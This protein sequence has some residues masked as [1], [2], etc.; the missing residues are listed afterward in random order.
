MQ[1]II[2]GNRFSDPKKYSWAVDKVAGANANHWSAQEISM[3]KDISQWKLG[4]IS[5]DEQLLV[6][7]NLG[8]FSTADSLAANNIILGLLRHIRA[9][10]VRNFLHRQAYDEG[11]HSEAYLYIVQSLG[12]DEAEIFNAYQEIPSIRD[13]DQFLIPFI[14]VL[15]DPE[16]E[17]G[18]FENDQALLKSVFV[19]SCLMEGLFFYTGFVQ[20]LALGRQNKLMGASQEYQLILKDESL[21][22]NFGI[23]LFN[24][25]KLECPE[26]WTMELKAE[27][28]ELM[29]QAV[30]LEY[31]Y[32]EDTMPRGVLGLNKE[33]F[34]SYLQFIANRR[35]IQC[36]M[37]SIYAGATN[38][39]P[40]LATMID[41]PREASFFEVNVT[42]YQQGSSL[43][44]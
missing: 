13:K 4:Q 14:N 2:H 7:R 42:T 32:A 1:S 20:I 27:L 9:E 6:K 39:F 5:P 15:A 43:E 24:T 41:Q 35:M 11:V 18:T 31:K 17:T 34:H 23:D 40:W 29:K 21:H 44:F 16:F 36:G 8:F 33:M 25:I 28:R 26:L 30:E 3:S 38:P 10:E 19:F 37:D 22:C 12:L